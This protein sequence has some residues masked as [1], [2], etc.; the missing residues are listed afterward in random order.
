VNKRFNALRNLSLLTS[1]ATKSGFFNG[2]LTLYAG[3]AGAPLT[4]LAEPPVFR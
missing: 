3:L 4:I 1:A 2:L